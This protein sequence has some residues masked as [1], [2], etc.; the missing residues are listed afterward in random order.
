MA[1][2]WRRFAWDSTMS[3]N[4]TLVLPAEEFCSMQVCT[5]TQGLGRGNVTIKS[6]DGYTC[7]REDLAHL[8]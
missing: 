1:L 7:T 8:D 3:R 6:S 5:V 4:S 2:R